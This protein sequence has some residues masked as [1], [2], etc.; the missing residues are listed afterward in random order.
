MTTSEILFNSGERQRHQ[1]RSRR[2]FENTGSNS[3]STGAVAFNNQGG[4]V[5]ATAGTLSITGGGTDTGGTYNALTGATVNLN[6]TGGTT[7]TL[8]GTYTG[9]GGGTVGL[10]GGTIAIG[11][12]GATFNFPAGLFQ[13]TGGTIAGPGTL[14]NTAVITIGGSGSKVNSGL[15]LNNSGTITEAGTSN[16]ADW[17]I[18]NGSTLNNL[19]GGI[20]NMTTSEILFNSGS[21]N[22]VNNEAGALFENTGSN[23]VSTGAVTFNNL[24]TVQATTG[25][26]TI[27]ILTQLSARADSGGTWI[28][29]APASRR[30]WRQSDGERWFD[31]A[32]CQGTF[33]Q[34]DALNNNVGSLSLLAG[35]SLTIT[36]PAAVWLAPAS[37]CRPGAVLSVTGNFTLS[38]PSS[39]TIQLGG[40]TS[41]QFG[42]LAV[43]GTATLTGASVTRQRQ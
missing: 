5:A 7:P 3:V 27:G 20:V 16:S 23:S 34:I 32:Q 19:S 39:V 17:G 13:W 41:S 18:E 40:P 10:P 31:H 4:T 37:C 28:A 38:S 14:S 11:T 21:G 8:T 33:A 36:P 22:A 42:T 1:Q 35:D 30:P 25:M 26:L 12:G 43:S 6:G 15:V 9:S 29:W 24:G 2:L